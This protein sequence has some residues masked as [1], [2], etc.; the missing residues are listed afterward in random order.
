MGMT[1]AQRL[2]GYDPV[3]EYDMTHQGAEYLLHLLYVHRD[4][5]DS[6][7]EQEYWQA[8]IDSVYRED[9]LMRS[10]WTLPQFVALQDR[11]SAEARHIEAWETETGWRKK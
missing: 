1:L 8:R 2:S 11:W 7:A 10:T 9:K 6:K 4:E 5:A 3:S